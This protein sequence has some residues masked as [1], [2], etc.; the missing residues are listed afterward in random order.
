VW[1]SKA[2]TPALSVP[3]TTAALKILM[4]Y[5]AAE[6]DAF[7]MLLPDTHGVK[8]M[9]MGKKSLNT[10]NS[11]LLGTTTTTQ[12]LF[13]VYP[14]VSPHACKIL[15]VVTCLMPYICDV[16]ACVTYS[17]SRT[18]DP[19]LRW[20]WRR[21]RCERGTIQNCRRRIRVHIGRSGIL[22]CIM[23][24][25]MEFILADT[26]FLKDDQD[27]RVFQAIH[28]TDSPVRIFSKI[29]PQCLKVFSFLMTGI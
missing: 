6:L 24:I 19:A 25:I 11:Q 22:L 17:S 4:K 16:L 8:V 3:E 21:G 10:F 20:I 26:P 5:R 13:T 23:H 15:P 29:R 1:L 27:L 12:S 28:K 2:G 18:P 14:A 9:T 7:G